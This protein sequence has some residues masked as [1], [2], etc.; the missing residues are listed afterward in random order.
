M[1]NNQNQF[2][3]NLSLA[4]KDQQYYNNHIVTNSYD[5]KDGK[6]GKIEHDD[7]CIRTKKPGYGDF[8]CFP[9]ARRAHVNNDPHYRAM[10]LNKSTKKFMTPNNSK[11]KNQSTFKKRWNSTSQLGIWDDMDEKQSYV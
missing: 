9:R 5:F 7:G 4:P 10:L 3:R 6:T 8:E 2:N 1:I 11:L